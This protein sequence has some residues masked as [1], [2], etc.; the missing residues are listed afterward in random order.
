M[1][2]WS[3]GMLAATR[4]KMTDSEKKSEQE[5]VQHFLLKTCN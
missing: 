3:G 4:G 5:H 1:K 2:F